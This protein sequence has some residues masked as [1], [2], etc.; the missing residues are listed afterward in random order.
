MRRDTGPP[1][2][3]APQ[4]TRSDGCSV[5][6]DP[7]PQQTQRC[8]SHGTPTRL[9][10]ATCGDP[11]CVDCAVRTAVGL[12]CPEH[13]RSRPPSTGRRGRARWILILVPLLLLVTPLL[14]SLFPLLS[15]D[16][17]PPAGSGRSQS[18]P[19]ASTPARAPGAAKPGIEGREP[20]GTAEPHT[21]PV[22][23]TFTLG[24]VPTFTGDRTGAH[25]L[26][27]PDRRR[28]VSRAGRPQELFEPPCRPPH[29]VAG[30]GVSSGARRD[31]RPCGHRQAGGQG[32]D[33]LRRQPGRAAGPARRQC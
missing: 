23:P 14:L 13:G 18:G 33:P 15:S 17:D 24:P 5:D 26:R 11:V 22:G 29:G 25:P 32:R 16:A 27:L 7:P 31:L 8:A 20:A 30:A 6:A 3:H 28:V 2:P 9:A 4:G 12:R 1:D 21:E 19:S 10:C